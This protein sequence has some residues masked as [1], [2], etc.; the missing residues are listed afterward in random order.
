[1]VLFCVRNGKEKTL[2]KETCIDYKVEETQ[3]TREECSDR[4]RTKQNIETNIVFGCNC[5]FS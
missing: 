5:L 3:Q 2:E 1:M 4:K